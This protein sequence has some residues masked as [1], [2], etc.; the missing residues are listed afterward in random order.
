MPVHS[1][2]ISFGQPGRLQLR[3][4]MMLQRLDRAGGEHHH[5]REAHIGRAEILHDDARQGERQALAAMLGRAGERAPA[6]LDIAAIGLAEAGRQG[7]ALGRPFRADLVADPVER[8]EFARREGARALDDRIDQIGRRFGERVVAG[9]LVH[10]DDVAEQELLFLDRRPVAHPRSPAALCLSGAAIARRGERAKH[11]HPAL[12][13]RGDRRGGAAD[14]GGSSR[15]RCRPRRSTASPP[16]R[17]MA[18]RWRES[19]KRREGRASTR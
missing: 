2:V 7:D 1:P 6:A 3:R 11:P 9:Q 13:A 10:A 8:R 12:W 18:R 4:A 14:R 19:T 5:Q 17:P 16:M 15:S